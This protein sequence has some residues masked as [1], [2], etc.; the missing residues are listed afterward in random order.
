M[1][2]RKVSRTARQ[3]AASRSNLIKA[4]QARNRKLPNAIGSKM[5]PAARTRWESGARIVVPRIMYH[6]K[7]IQLFHHTSP[8]SANKIVKEQTLRGRKGDKIAGIAK[9]VERAYFSTKL[10]GVA[11]GDYGKAAVS[12]RIPFRKAQPLGS[13]IS[14][15]DLKIHPNERFYAVT[16]KNLAGRK[17]KR[18][19]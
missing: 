13:A 9:G 2:K 3:A 12:I 5:K 1:P 14:L 4:R 6:G 15:R 17:I 19:R 8:T 10:G 18:A 11:S 16:R 7:S